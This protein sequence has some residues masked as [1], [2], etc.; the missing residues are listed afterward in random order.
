MFLSSQGR[1]RY[2]YVIV[3]LQEMGV[4][5]KNIFKK[6]LFYDVVFNAIGSLFWTKMSLS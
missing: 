4:L 6:K 3:L 1:L 5:G 2:T